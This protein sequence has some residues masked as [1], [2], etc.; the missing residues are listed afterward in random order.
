MPV[1]KQ[2]FDEF[3]ERRFAPEMIDWLSTMPQEVWVDVVPHLNWDSSESVLDWIIDQERCE[4]V[5]AAWIFWGSGLTQVADGGDFSHFRCSTSGKRCLRILKNLKRGFYRSRKLGLAKPDRDDLE[6]LVKRWQSL[7]PKAR[8]IDRDFAPPAEFLGPFNGRAPFAWPQYRAE[9]NPHVWDLFE[10][11][12]TTIGQ[13]PG[14][15][16]L[17]N[18]YI[19]LSDWRVFYG[20]AGAGTLILIAADQL[21]R[22]LS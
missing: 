8:N 10:G 16:N 1:R 19:P 12:G 15:S 9:N 17:Y 7:A 21:A 20:L 22:A 5:V 18:I 13:R 6:F 3:N 11:L 2:H 4:L 14:W